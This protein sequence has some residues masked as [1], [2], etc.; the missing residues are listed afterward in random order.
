V[1]QLTTE[2]ILWIAG[3]IAAVLNFGGW[4]AYVA[5][6]K[7]REWYE[8]FAAGAMLG[9][10]GVVVMACLPPDRDTIARSG[11]MLTQSREDHDDEQVK[12]L[13]DAEWAKRAPAPGRKLTPK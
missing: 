3:G 11:G 4:G 1:D 6:K 5:M 9:P 10:F 13:S 7:Q 12:R 2:Q 8:G